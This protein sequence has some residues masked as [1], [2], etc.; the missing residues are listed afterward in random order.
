MAVMV[1]CQEVVLFWFYLNRDG[2]NQLRIVDDQN[3]TQSEPEKNVFVLYVYI[4]ADKLG[5]SN[6]ISSPDRY[7][8][9][10]THLSC[11][12]KHNMCIV[13]KNFGL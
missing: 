3:S 9:R 7:L 8:E 6:P 13:T 4:Y 12:Q 11:V 2:T 5:A 10:G 1:S